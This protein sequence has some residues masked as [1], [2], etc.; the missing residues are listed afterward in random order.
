MQKSCA[1]S[2]FEK[3]HDE[4]KVTPEKILKSF[5]ERFV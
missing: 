4:S 1:L 3:R 5:V 2:L